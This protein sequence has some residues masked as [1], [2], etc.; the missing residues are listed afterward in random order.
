[1]S[2]ANYT[3]PGIQDDYSAD[4]VRQACEYSPA[5][6]NWIAEQRYLTETSEDNLSP[7]WLRNR[8]IIMICEE[9]ADM[10]IVTNIDPDDICDQP[11]LVYAVLMLR[12]KFD[13]DHL[14][15]ALKRNR[16]LADD[17]REGLDTDSV[18]RIINGMH[19][20][21]QLDD[22]WDM[23]AGT[24]TEHPQWIENNSKFIEY[25]EPIFDR[26]DALGD[27]DVTADISQDDMLEYMRILTIR[28]D[29][30]RQTTRKLWV[31]AGESE[32]QRIA[33][34]RL[35]D[36]YFDDGFEYELGSKQAVIRN[37]PDL[38]GLDLHDL[39]A[40]A[41]VIH[42]WRE[43]YAANWKHCLEYWAKFGPKSHEI[44]DHIVAIMISTLV[45]DTPDRS[46][47]R[48]AVE[49]HINSFIDQLGPENVKDFT[50]IFRDMM[51]NL[52]EPIEV[53]YAS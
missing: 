29:Y 3:D 9:L 32:Q 37:V 14:V 10:G 11:E 44:S 12:R 2:L 19:E 24:L 1:M 51:N 6:D 50:A 42:K 22:G 15:D 27:P 18:E 30:I 48:T 13:A 17:L 41:D 31:R 20:F 21:G 45:V 25:L 26:I 33:R 34:E 16:E 46:R 49:M 5:I 36:G 23:L 38:A 28:Q 47:V 53:T 35:I 52:V 4:V 39:H 43:P 7:Q 40:V 8:C